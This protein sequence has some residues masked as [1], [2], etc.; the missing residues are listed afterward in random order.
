MGCYEVSMGVSV[1]CVFPTIYSICQT[2]DCTQY[3]SYRDSAPWKSNPDMTT[4]RF[5]CSQD[6][7]NA[8][9]PKLDPDRPRVPMERYPCKGSLTIRI[10][11]NDLSRILVRYHHTL[12]HT[13]YTDISIPPDDMKYIKEKRDK[14]PSD[15]YAHLKTKYALGKMY[16]TQK[17]VYAAWQV[18]NQRTWKLDKDQLVSARMQLDRQSA[19]HVTRID[20]EPETGVKAFAFALAEVISERGSLIHEIGMDST[21]RFVLRYP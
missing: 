21:C 6:E 20:L 2:S 8:K 11:Q 7:A 10:D 13:H 5:I 19:D 3:C 9:K 4:Y 12:Q 16:Y 15:L 18:E 14:T 1:A 17:Q